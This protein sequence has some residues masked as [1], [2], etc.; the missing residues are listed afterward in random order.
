MAV[1]MTSP[2]RIERLKAMLVGETR[3]R[4]AGAALASAPEK[5]NN[6]LLAVMLHGA[7]RL[8]EGRELTDLERVLVDALRTV[9]DNEEVKEWGLAYRETVRTA[10]PR[11]L[12]VPLTITS[13][14][15]SW[16]YSI[17]DL[18]RRMPDLAQEAWEAPNVSLLRW[19]DWVAGRVEEDAAFVEAMGETGFAV[20]GIARY[21]ASSA[22][23]LSEDTPAPEAPAAT[24]GNEASWQARLDMESFYVERAVGDQ[25]GGRDEIYFSA[26]S[27][28]GGGGQAFIS[29][30]FGAVK[31][32]QTREFS[33]DKKVFLDLTAR[34][35][36]VT[37]I[38][39]WEADQSNAEWYDKLQ[40][41]LHTAVQIIEET[42][43]SNPVSNLVPV[44]DPVSISWEIAKVFIGL[45]DTLRNYDDLSCSRSFVLTREDMAILVHRPELEWNFNGDGHHKLRVRYTGDRPSYPTGALYCVSRTQDGEEAGEWSL[46]APFGWTAQ[47]APRAVVYNDRLC[48][49]WAQPK[50][51]VM[52]S[53]YDGTAWTTPQYVIL[54][55]D[56]PAAPVPANGTLE[57]WVSGA[58]YGKIHYNRMYADR[59]PSPKSSMNDMDTVVGPA[60][61]GHAGRLWVVRSAFKNGNALI[62]RGH[63]SAR[64]SRFGDEKTLATSSDPFGTCSMAHGRGRMWITALQDRTQMRTYWSSKDQAPDEAS[65]QSERGPQGESKNSPVLHVDG[66]NLWC[67]HT[68]MDGKPYLSRRVNETN[69]SPGTWSTPVPIGEQDRPAVLDTPG[70]VTYKGLMYAFYHA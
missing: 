54:N 1:E 5:S 57:C 48:V 35:S 30:E 66:Q 25:G 62:L 38:Q 36:I 29:E 63:M 32:G 22:G 41:A 28:A 58:T 52:S 60:L 42:L 17:A 56:H 53:W 21:P 26:S 3:S 16:G 43:E 15:S 14:P 39:V 49:F 46:P 7:N 27:S 51:A 12:I 61:A 10:L 20:T 40:L 24:A 34:G 33:S 55:T 69:S 13:R 19:E 47:T 59:W 64:D 6:L 70:I 9:V 4:R 67:A 68:D 50:G 2:E 65:W 11:R 8:R 45:M 44:P 18:R 31:K 23:T 37:G